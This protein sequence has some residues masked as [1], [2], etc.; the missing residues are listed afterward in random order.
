M[1]KIRYGVSLWVGTFPR[2]RRPAYPRHRGQTDLDVAI[3]G[4]GF[5]GCVTA[6]A[7]ASAGVRVAVF[8]ADQIGRGASGASTAMVMQE[9]DVDFQELVASSGLRA[10]RRI[11]QMTRKATF[12]LC[13]TVRRLKI[14][15]QLEA[16]ESLYVASDTDAV[17]RLRREHDARRQAGLEVRWLNADRVR[18]ETNLVAPGG[19]RVSGNAQLDPYRATIGFAAAAAKRGAGIYEHS[20]VDRVRFGRRDL[21]LRTE[22]GDVRA[23]HVVIA[24]GHPTPLFKSLIR[25]FRMMHTY[26]VATPSLGAKVRSALGRHETMVWDT[27]SPYHYLRW[28]RDNRVL[29]GGADQ[30]PTRPRHREKVLIQRAGQ[31]MYE[32]STRYPIISGIQPEF[33]WDGPC[34]ATSNGVPYIGPHRNYPRHLFAMGYGGNGLAFGFLA[35]RILLR[36]YLGEPAKGDE[37][38]AFTR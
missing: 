8:E 20:P 25:H 14:Q 1:A 35:S 6:H 28:T 38:F 31:L 29:F 19:I 2:T 23:S 10:A 34:A 11:W 12:D 30:P 21:Q 26:T 32:L 9:P 15:C 4:G 18:R 13:A 33:A 36:H 3:I 17:K 5:T 16:R 7:F 22:R 27:E 24:T 37:L